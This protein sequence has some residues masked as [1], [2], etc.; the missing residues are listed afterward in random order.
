MSMTGYLDERDLRK[1]QAAKLAERDRKEREW[2]YGD[3]TD[4]E[5]LIRFDAWVKA[6]LAARIDWTWA[7]E[8]KAKRIEQCKVGLENMVKQLW[9]R[10][11]HLD[12]KRLATLIKDALDEVGD[13]QRKGRVRDFWPFFNAV[14][15]R[16]VGANA[17]EIQQAAMS[18][19]DGAGRIFDQLL[20]KTPQQASMTEL[21]ARRADE[22]IREQVKRQRAQ[23]ARQKADASQPQ[24]F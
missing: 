21:V 19:G 2:L 11:W 20:R 9:S 4:A 10:G 16:Y 14:V 8:A 24:L 13:A 1:E 6:E 5:R 23:E 3:R 18:I 12:G 22:T 15:T 17:E 7:G